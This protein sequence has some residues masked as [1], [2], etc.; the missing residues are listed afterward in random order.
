MGQDER[1]ILAIPHMSRR[2]ASW[3]HRAESWPM[4]LLVLLPPNHS[5]ARLAIVMSDDRNSQV[6]LCEVTFTRFS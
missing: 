3:K 6:P 2:P 5:Q 4:W 1:Q